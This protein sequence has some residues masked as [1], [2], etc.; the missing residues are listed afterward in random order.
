MINNKFPIE[1]S[2][3][4]ASIQVLIADD[5]PQ[6]RQGLVTV[7]TLAMKN[8]QPV[9]NIV[10]EAQ[11]G[12]E[13]IDM[14]GSLQPDVILMDLEMPKLDGLV[15]IQRIKSAYPRIG[16]IV[17]SIHHD[18]LTHQRAAQAGADA[19]IEKGA[20]VSELLQAIHRYGR[21]C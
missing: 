10:G 4:K 13:A 8:L 19:F 14:A 16:I 15:A 6:V 11:N 3:M 12:S 17:L 18:Q 1:H 2:D 9:I 21:K 20:P 5:V 7:L